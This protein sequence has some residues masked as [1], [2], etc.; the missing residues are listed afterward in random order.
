MAINVISH[1]SMDVA[2]GA[3]RGKEKR[4]AARHAMKPTCRGEEGSYSGRSNKRETT[5]LAPNRSFYII[6]RP[7]KLECR[8]L[9]KCRP[10][11]FIVI[12]R[13]RGGPNRETATP[14]TIRESPAPEV[15]NVAGTGRVTRSRRIFAQKTCE[16]KTE[17]PR[18]KK[19]QQKHPKRGYTIAKVLIDNG[20]SLNVM[21]KATLH[22]LYL[23]NATL[24]NNP[25]VVKAFDGSKREVMGEI[26]L[27]IRIA[28]KTFNITF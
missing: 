27:P 2:E 21:P 4:S 23:P 7:L 14:L 24:K 15:T 17:H 10:C 22:K 6:I 3:K 1:E 26:T 18:K 5:T 9:F 8:S 25:V 11:Q 12:M 20:S 13:P 16:I 19:E 28:P